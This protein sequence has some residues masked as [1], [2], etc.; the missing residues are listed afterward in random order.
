MAKTRGIWFYT[1]SLRVGIKWYIKPAQDFI[2]I[3]FGFFIMFTRHHV[4]KKTLK[5]KKGPPRIS[6]FK[7]HFHK[8]EEKFLSIMQPSINTLPKI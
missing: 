8:V 6:F 1:Y 4:K 3:L 2:F 7:T 5:K